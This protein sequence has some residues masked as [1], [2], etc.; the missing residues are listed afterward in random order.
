MFSVKKFLRPLIF[1][2]TIIFVTLSVTGCGS[3]INGINQANKARKAFKAV[4]ATTDV[5]D[6][7]RYADDFA[8]K[9]L[10]HR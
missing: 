8:D 1:T 10:K 3:V 4:K 6:L 2:L 7:K 5:V 9:I